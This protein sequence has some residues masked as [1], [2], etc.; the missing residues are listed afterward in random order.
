MSVTVPI[1]LLERRDTTEAWEY[2]NPVLADKEAGFETDI[3]GAPIGMKMGDGVTHWDDLPYWFTAGLPIPP[4]PTIITAGVT[5]T[6][7]TVA[8]A[9]GSSTGYVLKR[10]SDGSFDWNTTV[11]YDG[12]VF[13]IIGDDKGD[14]TFADSY[15]FGIK[16]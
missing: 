14:G 1:T 13:T 2:T 11:K 6:P 16:P 10:T 4:S 9:G 12:S 15:I 5:A 7:L 8:Y 3:Y